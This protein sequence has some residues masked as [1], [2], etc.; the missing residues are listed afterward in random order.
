MI[1]RI[2]FI[3]CCLQALVA[4]GGG[5]DTKKDDDLKAGDKQNPSAMRGYKLPES[6]VILDVKE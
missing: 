5:S 1:F 2:L 4:C 6:I 3:L